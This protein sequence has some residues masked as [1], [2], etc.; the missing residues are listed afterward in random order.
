MDN[1]KILR[2]F[3]HKVRVA[4]LA[5]SDIWSVWKDV[6]NWPQW[7]KGLAQCSIN[8]EFVAGNTFS[9]LP[10]GEVSSDKPF[11]ATLTR[12]KE[13]HAFDDITIV[14]WGV[15]NGVHEV[16]IIGDEIEIYHEVTAEVTAD[17]ID[18]FDSVVAEKWKTT[19][20]AAL[21]C[22]IAIAQEKIARI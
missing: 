22:V 3:K 19:L 14:P 20:P 11:I 9:L 13:N 1:T 5:P 7:N 21:E 4:G 18:F 15:V 17:K 10:K 2:Q 12:V 8:G 6:D 16:S